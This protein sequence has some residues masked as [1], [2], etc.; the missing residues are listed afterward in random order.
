[1]LD[2][3][4]SPAAEERVLISPPASRIGPLD[5]AERSAVLQRSPLK[6]RYDTLVDRES[7][8]EML[9]HKAAQRAAE[10]ESAAR[11]PARTLEPAP[12]RESKP[13]KRPAAARSNRQSASEAFMKSTLRSIGSSL[14]RQIARGL[15]GSIL[16]K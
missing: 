3:Q 6:G 16:G 9:A 10:S 11:K 4:G 1:V 12:T 5:A 15:L 2:R 8:H 14:G 13:A 7:A